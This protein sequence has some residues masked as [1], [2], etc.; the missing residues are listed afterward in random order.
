MLPEKARFIADIN[1]VSSYFRMP[2]KTKW[3]EPRVH[4]S[5]IKKG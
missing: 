3:K 4:N 1:K 5:L 2:I